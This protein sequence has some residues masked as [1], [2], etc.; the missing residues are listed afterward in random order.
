[1][2]PKEYEKNPEKEFKK[3]HMNPPMSHDLAVKNIQL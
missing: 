2:E 1:M 3:L